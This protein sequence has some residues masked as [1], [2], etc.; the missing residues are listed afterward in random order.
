[1]VGITLGFLVR[2]KGEISP[3]HSRRPQPSLLYVDTLPFFPLKAVR[4]AGILFINTVTQH[5][6]SLKAPISSGKSTPFRG[7][8]KKS[9]SLLTDPISGSDIFPPFVAETSGTVDRAASVTPSPI[10]LPDLSEVVAL[11]GS[12]S[13]KNSEW[14]MTD[15]GRHLA[16]A[17]VRRILW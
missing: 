4:D 9:A 15:V 11:A 2:R 17:L 6:H 16:V 14:G 1:M 8:S 3:A 12:S 13:G 10:L 5:G 7:K